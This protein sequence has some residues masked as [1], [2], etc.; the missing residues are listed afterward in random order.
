ME[1]DPTA[2]VADMLQKLSIAT[3]EERKSLLSKARPFLLAPDAGTKYKKYLENGDFSVIFDCL[4]SAD[5]HVV[6]ATCEILSRIFEFI[7]P[8]V[9]LDKYSDFLNRCLT[10]P[11]H[12]VKEVILGV[13]NKSLGDNPEVEGELLPQILRKRRARDSNHLGGKTRYDTYRSALPELAKR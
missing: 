12:S 7:N 10:H 8:N 13:M 11:N 6:Q 9:V 1:E 3:E 5:K 4:N 2:S